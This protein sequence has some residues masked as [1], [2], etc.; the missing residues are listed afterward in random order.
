MKVL[1]VEDERVLNDIIAKRLK[2]AKFTVDT[3]YDGQ[4]ALDYIAYGVYDVIILDIMLPE[5]NG[6]DVLKTIRRN[7]H[8]TPV[9]LL[10]AKDTVLDRVTGLDSGADD[11]LVK[12]FAFD[13][14]LAR[15]RALIRRPAAQISN[16]F[17]LDDMLIDFNTR[18]VSRSGVQVTLTGKEFNVLEL[19]ARNVGIVLT[20]DKISQH[21]WSYDYDGSSNVID[22]FIRY[23]RRKIDDGHDVKLIHT[24]RGVGYV[25]KVNE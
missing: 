8:F 21:L 23:L 1:I 5:V 16:T 25:L 3:C 6:L 20:R 15:L 10:T 14:L 13:E 19:L 7:K 18:S 9:L 24:V 22:V 4:S 17:H 11:Y 12:P 2:A